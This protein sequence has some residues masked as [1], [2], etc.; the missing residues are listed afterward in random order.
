MAT[1]VVGFAYGCGSDANTPEPFPDAGHGDAN[2]ASDG[3]HADVVASDA[4]VTC[5]PGDVTTF[6]APTYQNASGANQGKCTPAQITAFYDDC[7]AANTTQAT[8]APFTG[9]SATTANKAC[10]SCIVTADTAMKLGPVVEHKGIISINIPGCMELLDP[11]GGLS[12]AKA[13][14]ASDACDRAACAANCPVTDDASFMLYQA[15][16]DQAAAGGCSA[17]AQ[18]AACATAE[19]DAAATKVCFAGQTFQDLYDG[20]VPVFCGG[21]APDSGGGD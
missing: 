9:T 19:A 17:F 10:A 7:L 20:V 11:M 13:Y 1:L 2:S 15:C 5:M 14:Q 12:C 6:Q 4:N 18:G 3:G 16:T 21:S 8:C